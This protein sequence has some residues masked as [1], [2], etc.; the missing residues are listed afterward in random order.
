MNHKP[1]RFLIAFVS[2]ALFAAMAGASIASADPQT[3]PATPA[4]S[5]AAAPAPSDS[6]ALD[7]VIAGTWRNPNNTAR[8]KYRHP[9]QTLLFFGVKPTQTVIEI[10]PGSGWYTEW[11]APLVK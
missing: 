4:A 7:Q 3:P 8:D 5:P 2:C 9:K 10:T 11:L 1:N 6:A